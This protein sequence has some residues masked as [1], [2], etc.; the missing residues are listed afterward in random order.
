M[1]LRAREAISRYCG[2]LARSC[3]DAVKRSSSGGTPIS[4]HRCDP[5]SALSSLPIHRLA[6]ALSNF[7]ELP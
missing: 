3:T 7:K 4:T 6:A 2:V 1:A 5:A